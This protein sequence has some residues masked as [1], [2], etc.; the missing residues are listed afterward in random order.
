M[1]GLGISF[2]FVSF[3][4]FFVVVVLALW[5]GSRAVW[6]LIFSLLVCRISFKTD[7]IL[8]S[9]IEDAGPGQ[10]DDNNTNGGVCNITY[11]DL[12]QGVLLSRR[13]ALQ[14]TMMHRSLALTIFLW[15]WLNNSI[16]T[17]AGCALRIAFPFAFALAGRLRTGIRTGSSRFGRVGFH[18]G[19][20]STT[21]RR[22]VVGWEMYMVRL[23]RQ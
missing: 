21:L 17:T 6:I 23:C 18:P 16:P 15:R 1:L 22:R 5:A 10:D 4:L 20:L 19:Q 3:S 12:P 9:I 7:F 13:G 8:T 2:V 14:D 11:T